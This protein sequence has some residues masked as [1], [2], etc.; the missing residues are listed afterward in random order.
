MHQ[1]YPSS[2]C[3]WNSPISSRFQ[4]DSD[5]ALRKTHSKAT[6]HSSKMLGWMSLLTLWFSFTAL[7]QLLQ[8]WHSLSGSFTECCGRS[9]I[10]LYIYAEWVH[11]LLAQAAEAHCSR[12]HAD[13]SCLESIQ[14][15]AVRAHCGSRGKEGMGWGAVG[16]VV[17]ASWKKK[18]PQLICILSKGTTV[19]S[20]RAQMVL[21][22]GKREGSRGRSTKHRFFPQQWSVQSIHCCNLS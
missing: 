2:L 11:P 19:S 5:L 22:W 18:R 8:L 6:L 20:V 10:F 14:P 13:T 15:P 12:G 1:K 4:E 3:G 16:V 21:C 7:G 9:L 17:G